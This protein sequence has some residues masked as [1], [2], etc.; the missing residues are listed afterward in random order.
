MKTRFFYIALCLIALAM[1]SCKKH[2]FANGEL[3]PIMSVG[4]LRTLFKGADVTLSKDKMLG[5][6]QITG[7][8]ISRP[9]SGNVPQGIVVMQNYRRG[10]LRGISFPLGSA[11]DS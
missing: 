9:D 6:Y 2:D 3:S 11:A 4:D 10:Q 5:A 7:T 1:G 8:V